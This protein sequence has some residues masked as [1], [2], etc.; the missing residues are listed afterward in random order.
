MHLAQAQAKHVESIAHLNKWRQQYVA[1][2]RPAL[3][4]LNE[5]YASI[6]SE[7]PQITDSAFRISF[8]NRY[9][10]AFNALNTAA[11][12]IA[13][14]YNGPVKNERRGLNFMMERGRKSDSLNI[15]S[16]IQLIGSYCAYESKKLTGVAMRKVVQEDYYSTFELQSPIIETKSGRQFQARFV[17]P[18][19]AGEKLPTIFR[20]NIYA[21]SLRDVQDARYYADA[22]YASVV[23]N[24][25]GKGIKAHEVAP[26]EFDGQDAN[27]LIDWIIDQDW[28]DGNIGMVGGSYLGFAQW[29]ALKKPHPALKTIIPKVSVGPGIDYP[30]TSN[31]FMTYMIRWINY[32]IGSGREATWDF[33]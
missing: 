15:T 30:M 4:L 22:G 5:L 1:D 29:A 32:V 14:M 27:E 25:R 24:T 7:D 23:I 31:V 20:F 33:S 11:K 10:D 19:G 17:K 9:R 2:Y 16:A 6:K 28:C 21:D 12:E 26:F 18:K 13:I 8:E 3:F